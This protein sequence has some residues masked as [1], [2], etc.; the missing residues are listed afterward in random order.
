MVTFESD[1]NNG[2]HPEVLRRL[3][4]TNTSP[5]A[6]Y[7]FD[8]WSES[9]RKKIREACQ[10]PE[11]DIFFLVGG[12]QANATVIVAMLPSYGA[13]VAVELTGRVVTVASAVGLITVAGFVIRNGLLL[14]NRYAELEREG[15][16]PVEAIRLGSRE[17]MVPILMTSLTTVFGLVPIVAALDVPGGEIL[18]PLAAVQLGGL[19]VATIAALIVVPALSALGLKS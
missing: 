15:C 11:A 14:E 1:Y 6:S 5:S 2:A 16:D 17:R 12:T 13:V 4:E 8:E 9:A 10:C 3:M 19:V 18:A 7:G